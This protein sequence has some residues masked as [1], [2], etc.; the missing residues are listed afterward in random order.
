MGGAVSLLVDDQLVKSTP[1]YV[2]DE[3]H[4]TSL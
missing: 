4:E 1:V 3:R 2:V